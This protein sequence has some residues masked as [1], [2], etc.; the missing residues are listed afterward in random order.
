MAHFLEGWKLKARFNKVNIKHFQSAFCEYWL[1]N[2]FSNMIH[3]KFL[4]LIKILFTFYLPT[5]SFPGRPKVWPESPVNAL[6]ISFWCRRAGTIYFG[7][8]M[9]TKHYYMHNMNYSQTKCQHQYQD[10]SRQCR[11]LTPGL[12]FNIWRHTKR[13]KTV[14]GDRSMFI[15]RV[16]LGMTFSC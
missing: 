9:S 8:R 6:S 5:V 15:Y 4:L 11:N 1:I 14:S 13:N 3:L 12:I 2:V 7:I 10:A 16:V